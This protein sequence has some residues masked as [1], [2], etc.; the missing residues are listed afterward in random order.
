MFCC[1]DNILAV[2]FLV[3][4]TYKSYHNPKLNAFM[5][6]LLP[7]KGLAI[8]SAIVATPFAMF[9]WMMTSFGLM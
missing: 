4:L 2:S 5:E 8:W 7:G 3:P 6:D 1:L 9:Y